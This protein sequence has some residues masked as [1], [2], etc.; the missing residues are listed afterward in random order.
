MIN[1]NIQFGVSTVCFSKI[2]L[3]RT[4]N[5]I[6]M[7]AIEF[8]EFHEVQENDLSNMKNKASY[9][10]SL[11]QNY[12]LRVSGIHLHR[13]SKHLKPKELSEYILSVLPFAASLGSDYIVIH[14]PKVVNEFELQMYFK[15]LIG[16]IGENLIKMKALLSI[17]FLRYIPNTI[18]TFTS[19][20][21][22]YEEI[23]LKVTIDTEHIHCFKECS[24]LEI[25]ESMIKYCNNIHLR[26]WDNNP[27]CQDGT[28]RYL[29]LGEGK[30]KFKRISKYLKQVQGYCT[31]E[32]PISGQ[33][34]LREQVKLM[35]N[36]FNRN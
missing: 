18:N 36:I 30:I 9:Y 5:L 29:P 34:Q 28:R 26:D 10:E 1:K 22:N 19:I 31:L 4:L 12:K 7:G 33:T 24:V 13:S 2:S 17:E 16:R 27:W 32:V 3:E 21:R 20:L 6:S 11:L 15:D 25:L 35:K 23:P 8:V 14:P